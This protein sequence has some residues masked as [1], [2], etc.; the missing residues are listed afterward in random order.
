MA[1]KWFEVP[2]PGVRASGQSVFA[3]LYIF[4]ATYPPKWS[5]LV[6]TQTGDGG[7]GLVRVDQ[8]DE[9][10]IAVIEPAKKNTLVMISRLQ[11]GGSG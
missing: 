5:P 7:A 2:S 11:P 6:S 1:G 4:A 10:L 9:E 3:P 8:V